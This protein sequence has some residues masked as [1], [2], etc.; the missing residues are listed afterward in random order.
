MSVVMIAAGGTD[1]PAHSTVIWLRRWRFS[2]PLDL[3]ETLF[4]YSMVLYS[5]LPV[6]ALLTCS[7]SHVECMDVAR[8]GLEAL[9]QLRAHP[10][11]VV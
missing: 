2:K 6:S 1:D 10:Y 8:D 11:D 9:R 4:L 7:L 5:L 3:S